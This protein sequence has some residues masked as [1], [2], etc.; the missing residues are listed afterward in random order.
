MLGIAKANNLI[1]KLF[2]AG[3]V[4]HMARSGLFHVKEI[5]E[6]GEWKSDDWNRYVDEDQVLDAVLNLCES[7]DRVLAQSD[8]EA[9]EDAKDI[10]QA[11]EVGYEAW[12]FM[13]VAEGEDGYNQHSG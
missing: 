7:M 11:G 10:W 6:A 4:A 5:T 2:R 8:S 12:C 1:F 3:M 13:Q 9:E